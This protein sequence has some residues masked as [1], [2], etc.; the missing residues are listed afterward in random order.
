MPESNIPRKQKTVQIWNVCKC[1]RV[2]H[3]IREATTGECS[4]CWMK[5]MRKDTKSALGKL[6]RAT[7]EPTSD[8]EKDN[9]IEDAMQKLDRDNGATK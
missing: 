9:L 4:G 8:E 5:G 7:L 6:I 1:G 2:L 3:S